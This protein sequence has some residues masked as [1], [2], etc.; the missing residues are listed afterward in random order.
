MKMSYSHL[1]AWEWDGNILRVN[2]GKI[3]GLMSAVPKI[4]HL[5]SVYPRPPV[6]LPA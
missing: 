2:L 5:S 1:F 3:L 6:P 4:S